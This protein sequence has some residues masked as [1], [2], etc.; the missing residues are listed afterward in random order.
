MGHTKFLSIQVFFFLCCC[1]NG[2][3]FYYQQHTLYSR[4]IHAFQRVS[5]A[6]FPSCIFLSLSKAT[7]MMLC[8]FL[9]ILYWVATTKLLT[10]PSRWLATVTVLQGKSSLSVHLLQV[11]FIR[12]RREAGLS[13]Q[14]GEYSLT[15]L[16]LHIWKCP[17]VSSDYPGS[18]PTDLGGFKS[19][20]FVWVRQTEL[21]LLLLTRTI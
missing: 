14:Q 9:F 17:H 15:F 12:S 13:V 7:V 2:F 4:H 5:K 11:S 3:N 21:L 19:P 1:F 16:D 18:L 6:W 8:G 10:P 20:V